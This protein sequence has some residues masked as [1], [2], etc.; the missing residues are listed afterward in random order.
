MV[1]VVKYR[2]NLPR[3]MVEVQEDI[4]GKAGLSLNLAVDVP[5]HCKGVEPDDL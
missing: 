5:V 4:Q 1:K 3:D 2:N